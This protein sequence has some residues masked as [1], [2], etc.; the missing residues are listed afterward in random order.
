M[1]R[2]GDVMVEAQRRKDKEERR[3]VEA[4]Q[5]MRCGL[6]ERWWW[7]SGGGSRHSGGSGAGYTANEGSLEEI[8]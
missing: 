7:R 5:T 2:G 6:A 4:V 3:G 8:H 1:I